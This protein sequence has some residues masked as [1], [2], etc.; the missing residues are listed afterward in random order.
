MEEENID[1]NI[2][3]D[4]LALANNVCDI[5]AS[6]IDLNSWRKRDKPIFL[7]KNLI[8]PVKGDKSKKIDEKL[9]LDN[10]SDCVIWNIMN[11]ENN[12]RFP[13]TK[14]S[15]YSDLYEKGLNWLTRFRKLVLD[16]MKTL[17]RNEYLKQGNSSRWD[18]I[19]NENGYNYHNFCE[20]KNDLKDKD[21]EYVSD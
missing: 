13:N 17:V 16:E 7:L 20:M 1:K 11:L 10:I 3:I 8:H 12:G 5:K 21:D 18:L 2:V 14:P 4:S 15:G 19:C 6:D 9:S